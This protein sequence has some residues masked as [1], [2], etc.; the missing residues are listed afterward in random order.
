MQLRRHTRSTTPQPLPWLGAPRLRH[1]DVPCRNCVRS[2]ITR[3]NVGTRL[4]PQQRSPEPIFVASLCSGHEP[5]LRG[6]VTALAGDELERIA[7]TEVD[8]EEALGDTRR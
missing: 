5:A 4:L 3:M 8:L 1:A 6:A 2:K 7:E